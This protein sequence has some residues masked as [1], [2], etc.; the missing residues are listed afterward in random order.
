MTLTLGFD[1]YGTL[2]DTHGVMLELEKIIGENN[3]AYFS[4]V[5]RD[6][7]LEYT[8]RRTAMRKYQNFDICTRQAL[9]HTAQTLDCLLYT[10]PSPR[11]A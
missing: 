6:K 1:V 7:Q 5:W 8:F 10:S 9:E 2:I 4:Q 11:D 3:A